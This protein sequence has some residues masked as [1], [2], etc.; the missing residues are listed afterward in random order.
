MGTLCGMNSPDGMPPPVT[1]REML[2]APL[3][4]ALALFAVHGSLVLTSSLAAGGDLVNQLLPMMISWIRHG[5]GWAPGTFAGHPLFA[6]PQ[7]GTLYPPNWL[8]LLGGEAAAPRVM[9][10]LLM[11]HLGWAGLG[12][13]FLSRRFVGIAG[14]ALAAGLWM[15][16]G[17]YGTRL[18]AGITVFVFAGAHLAWVVLGAEMLLAPEKP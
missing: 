6:D 15:F 8:F 4:V 9:T 13:Y 10:L 7:L 11:A 12:T 1:R 5:A 2:L 16:G 18:A 3:C 14:A 17:V